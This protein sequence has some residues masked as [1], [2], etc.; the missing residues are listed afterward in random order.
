MKKG[1]KE[2]ESDLKYLPTEY[3]LCREYVTLTVWFFVWTLVTGRCRPFDDQKSAFQND[4]ECGRS[5][6][7]TVAVGVCPGTALFSKGYSCIPG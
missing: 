4:V 3:C 2:W 1:A 7:D 6:A 5:A